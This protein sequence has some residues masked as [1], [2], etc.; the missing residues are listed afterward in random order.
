MGTI[1]NNGQ[2][3]ECTLIG[4]NNLLQLNRDDYWECPKCKLQLQNVADEF[5]GILLER[6]SGQFRD[7]YNKSEKQIKDRILVRKPFF[8]GDDCILKNQEELKDYLSKVK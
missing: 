4:Q 3:P 2:C 1:L 5:I 6:G 8:D 7:N